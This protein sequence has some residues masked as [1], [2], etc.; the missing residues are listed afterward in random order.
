RFVVD[1]EVVLQPVELRTGEHR[2]DARHARRDRRVDRGDAALRDVAADECCV[3]QAGDDDVVDVA[4]APG[5]EPRVLMAGDALA[6]E[7]S[8]GGHASCPVGA[9]A[10]A[11]RTASMIPW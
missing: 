9:V 7:A 6:D 2:D 1:L 3:Q 8:A 4:A 10:A 11:M 5:E